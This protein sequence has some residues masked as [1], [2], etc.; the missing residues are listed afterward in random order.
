VQQ[1]TLQKN[2]IVFLSKNLDQNMPKIGLFFGKKNAKNVKKLG[3]PSP[4][5]RL[6]PAAGVPP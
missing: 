4:T 3:A 5:A 6:P 2:K 1:H